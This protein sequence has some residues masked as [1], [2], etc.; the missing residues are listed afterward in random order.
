MECFGRDLAELLVNGAKGMFQAIVE[1]SPAGSP[2]ER[3]VEVAGDSPDTLFL[4]W[5]RELLFIYDTER[6]LPATFQVEVDNG[7]KASALLT[8][9]TVADEVILP[10]PIKAVTYHG[11]RV[12]KAASGIWKAQVVFDT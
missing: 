10:G 9:R 2:R 5:L 8:G 3:T 7:Y 1:E 6:F 11:L 4:S 12:E